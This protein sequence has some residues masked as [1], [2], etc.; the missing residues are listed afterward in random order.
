MNTPDLKRGRACSSRPWRI[1]LLALLYFFF[2]RLIFALDSQTSI[3]S[4]LFFIPEGIALAFALLYG[5]SM[6]IGVFVGQVLLALSAGAPP[7]QAIGLGCSNGLEA[8]LA[9]FL[10]Q[11]LKLDVS[12]KR[13]RD[14][15][16][17]TGLVLLILQPFSA[18]AAMLIL[19]KFTSQ[20]T[21]GAASIKIQWINWWL[22]N[23]MAQTQL[24]PLLLLLLAT[25]RK[26]LQRSSLI[27]ATKAFPILIIILAINFYWGLNSQSTSSGSVLTLMLTPL[28]VATALRTNKFALF[29]LYASAVTLLVCLLIPIQANSFL[30]G[31]EEISRIELRI[32]AVLIISQAVNLTTIQLQAARDTANERAQLL[33]QQLKISLMAAA[34]THEVKQPIAS[35]QLAS[36]QL[37]VSSENDR[38]HLIQC[39]MQSAN[40]LSSSTA[41]VHNLLRSL[42]AGLEPLDLTNVLAF[43]LLQAKAKLDQD[44][45]SFR[46]RGLKSPHWIM[47]DTSQIS[48]AIDNLLRNSIQELGRLSDD[49]PR[50]VTVDITTSPS[51]VDLSIGDN[52]PG[53]PAENWN[54]SLF[55][56]SK[57]EGTGLGLYLVQQMANNHN[58][59]LLFGRSALGGAQ[60]TIRFPSSVQLAEMDDS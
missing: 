53:F 54:P 59:Q 19:S 1:A 52:G 58:A 7:W 57:H 49:Q 48:L 20:S 32:F 9:C 26:I 55:E 4:P 29:C 56:T 24:T 42:P 6:A 37:L 12:F 34:L 60:V 46:T 44:R 38:K 36:Q 23:A 39:L 22:S 30:A 45:V 35:I 11:G 31:S 25:P 3:V 40:E 47:G 8:L 5:R 16:I 10:A 28:I 18:S 13:Q 2:G 43:G 41:K 21:V 33:A 27:W 14:F 17:L 15:W 50:L 51:T